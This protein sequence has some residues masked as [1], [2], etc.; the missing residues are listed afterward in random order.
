MKK[1]VI[2]IGTTIIA[3]I[4]SPFLFSMRN[5]T[6]ISLRYND[7]LRI[8]DVTAGNSIT[9]LT[10]VVPEQNSDT[11]EL[12]VYHKIM[13]FVLRKSEKTATRL[14]YVPRNVKYIKYE[15][16][17]YMINDLLPICSR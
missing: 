4:I 6:L 5:N 10:S 16:E 13:Y 3:L 12:Q 15:D 9:Y 17:I 2:I 11:L 1:K 14:L 7:E 8:L